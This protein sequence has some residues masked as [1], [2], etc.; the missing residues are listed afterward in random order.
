M[1]IK[2]TKIKIKTVALSSADTHVNNFDEANAA[3]VQF[4]KQNFK[5]FIDPIPSNK[6][7]RLFI[8]HEAF[9]HPINTPFM[10]KDELKVEIIVSYFETI[11]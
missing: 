11:V 6:K 8:D 7:V 3:C 2:S 5:D 9:S 10:D 4:I 1:N